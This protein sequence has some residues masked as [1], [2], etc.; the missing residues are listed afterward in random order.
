MRE[1]SDG[2]LLAGPADFDAQSPSSPAFSRIEWL[3]ESCSQVP[4]TT[5][6]EFLAAAEQAG[7]RP[8]RG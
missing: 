5:F 4:V 6:N 2:S 8:V 1:M 7:I 3:P